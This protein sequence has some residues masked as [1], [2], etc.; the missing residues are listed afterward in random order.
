MSVDDYLKHIMYLMENQK[1][2]ELQNYTTWSADE[3]ILLC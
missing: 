3:Q 1:R 2:L